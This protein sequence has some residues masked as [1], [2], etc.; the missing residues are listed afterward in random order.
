MDAK[1]PESSSL[2][3]LPNELT[4]HFGATKEYPWNAEAV[5]GWLDKNRALLD[6][7][8]AIALMPDRSSGG[9]SDDETRIHSGSAYSEF[10]KAFLMEARLFAEQ[11][12]VTRALESIRAAKGLANHLR[13]GEAPTLMEGFRGGNIQRTIDR[14]V[15]SNILPVIPARQVDV[16]AWENAV[17]PTLREPEDFTRMIRGEWNIYMPGTLLPALADSKDSSTPG[18]AEA[19]A[20]A[21]TRSFE[22]LVTRNKSLTLADLPSNPIVHA[23]YKDLSRRSQQIA[24]DHGMTSDSYNMRDI[25][26]GTQVQTGMTRAAFAILKGQPIP[27]DP[28]H[29]LPYQWDPATRKLSLPDIPEYKKSGVRPMVLPKF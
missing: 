29:G 27:N 6:E 9:M 11:G 26:Q 24:K 14:Y 10:S 7:S 25:W 28:V 2:I 13:D 20:E 15:F 8:R 22:S 23:S 12:D 1:K 19:M 5:K 21:Y 17:N 4:A 18:D 3:D 16:P